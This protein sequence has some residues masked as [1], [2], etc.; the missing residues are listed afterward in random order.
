MLERRVGDSGVE[1]VGRRQAI[2]EVARV[3]ARA[4][5]G[6]EDAVEERGA[7]LGQLIEVDGCAAGLGHDGEEAGSGRG[8]EYDIAGPQFGGGYGENGDLGRSGE[9]VQ[10][11][12]FFA[13]A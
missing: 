1:A 8:L 13:A 6:G 7:V 5:G 11:H 9:L 4:R 10:L 12:L 3:V 2:G